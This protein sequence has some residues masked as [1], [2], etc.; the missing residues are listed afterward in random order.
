MRVWI[1][2]IKEG[3]SAFDNVD[4]CKNRIKSKMGKIVINQQ[5]NGDK[6]KHQ[7]WDKV[8]SCIHTRNDEHNL[9]IEKLIL[10]NYFVPNNRTI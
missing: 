9:E 2:D 3:Q 4:D 5:K 7:Y 10:S 8:G 1:A 6:Y